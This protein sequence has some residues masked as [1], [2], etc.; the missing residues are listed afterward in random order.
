[1]RFAAESVIRAAPERVFAFHQLPDAL[2]RL[3]PAFAG[4]RVLEGGSSVEVGARTAVRIRLAPLVWVRAEYLHTACDP[5]HFFEDRQVRGP[6]KRWRHRHL[7]EPH[8]AG[9]RLID[10]IELEPPFGPAGRL[11]APLLVLPRLRRIFAWRHEV[12]R[13]WC[14]GS[15]AALPTELC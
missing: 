15:P 12:T 3:T 2:A 4:V 9:A 14:E 8:P 13:A 1:M 5:P 7:I 11:L 10:E 6:W